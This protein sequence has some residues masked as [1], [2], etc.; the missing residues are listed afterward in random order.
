MILC[1]DDGLQTGIIL[2]NLQKTFDNLDHKILLNEMKCIGF[3]EE[4]I[5][6]FHSYLTRKAFFVSLV[7]AFP[8]TGTKSYVVPL[9]S[10]LG[11]LLFFV[12][13]KICHLLFQ[14]TIHT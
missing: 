4:L 3:S 10:I 6:C 14:T 1:A 5:K 7:I 13:Q 12:I 9:G 11:M 2:I 8:K